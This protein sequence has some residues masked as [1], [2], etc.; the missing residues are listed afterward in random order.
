M[1]YVCRLR[2]MTDEQ[3][4]FALRSASIAIEQT[5]TSADKTVRLQRRNRQR[6]LWRVESE[7]ERRKMKFV[8]PETL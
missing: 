4:R 5:Y 3:I 6:R 1:S 7:A 8:G 2:N